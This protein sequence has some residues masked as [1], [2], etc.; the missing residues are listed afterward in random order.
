MK[1]TISLFCL[2]IILLFS[3][4]AFSQSNI[5]LYENGKVNYTITQLL[6]SVNA[7]RHIVYY[8][9][10][11]YKLE[12]FHDRYGKK[13]DTLN[14]WTETG[15]LHHREIHTDSGYVEMDYDYD[16]GTLLSI[17]NYKLVNNDRQQT[18]VYDSV[19]FDK[20]ISEKCKDYCYDKVGVWKYY[21]EKGNIES[22]GKYLAPK[23]TI[24]Y[25]VKTDSNNVMVNVPKTSFEDSEIGI[26]CTTFLKDSTWSFYN[27]KGKR[28]KEER[29]KAGLLE[30]ST[31]AYS[32]AKFYAE[33][34][35]FS[36]EISEELIDTAGRYRSFFSVKDSIS[37]KD[38]TTFTLQNSKLI[39]QY[40]SY[41]STS[42]NAKVSV[43]YK[44]S[45][46]DSK[47]V[48]YNIHLDSVYYSILTHDKGSV[49]EMSI[50]ETTLDH[51][52]KYDLGN[53]TNS[54]L[55]N[56]DSL[57]LNFDK[58]KISYTKKFFV[59]KKNKRLQKT[60]VDSKV[61][62]YYDEKPK[63]SFFWSLRSETISQK[64]ISEKKF[65]KLKPIKGWKFLNKK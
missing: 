40:K 24:R 35:L 50:T 42:L 1:N 52:I 28:I 57:I 3:F 4:S 15:K 53:Y 18:I 5:G 56:L 48:V 60:T 58:T 9:P 55:A 13:C 44:K 30:D 14:K 20:F 34:D 7:Y 2:S 21:N 47:E 36:G 65:N 38:T 27:N 11:G 46:I 49:H 29:Y 59:T 6:D 45:S 12:E 32:K 19:R 54:S 63:G 10:N 26:L 61:S 23:F 17:G 25:P 31:I 33:F 43:E 8:H 62:Y 37:T 41:F 22:E 51:Q 64:E 39:S 16:N